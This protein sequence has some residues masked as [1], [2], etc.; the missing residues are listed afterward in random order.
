VIKSYQEVFKENRNV[1]NVEQYERDKDYSY[2]LSEIKLKD[3]DN[4]NEDNRLS[5]IVNRYEN[6]E[7]KFCQSINEIDNPYKHS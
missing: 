7:N 5:K 2:L 6:K 3:G 1:G 4:K